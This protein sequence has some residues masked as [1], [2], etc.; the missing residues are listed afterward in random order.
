MNPLIQL[1]M[2]EGRL[3]MAKE[4]AERMA[5]AERRGSGEQ[6]AIGDQRKRGDETRAPCIT[7]LPHSP[8]RIGKDA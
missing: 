4:R 7:D 1:W 5:G 6:A 8:E 2:S 3:L